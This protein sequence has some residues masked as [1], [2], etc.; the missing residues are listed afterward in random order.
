M[1]LDIY[2]CSQFVLVNATPLTFLDRFWLN[3][4]QGKMRM[5]RC[6]W[7]KDF[8]VCQFLHELWPLTLNTFSQL[9][10]V[11]ATL[12][13]FLDGMRWNLAHIK[14]MLPR[15][16]WNEDFH[17]RRFVQEL[18]TLTVTLV[19][20]LFLLTQLFLH[21]STDF[22]EPWHKERWWCLDVHELRIFGFVLTVCLLSFTT[23]WSIID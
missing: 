15:C 6:A 5:P 2:T 9:F 8:P 14:M 11:N 3:L 16:A 23:K 4:A 19:Q 22:D 10:L 18:W 1:A 12:P 17:V 7:I 13:T 21:F 20:N